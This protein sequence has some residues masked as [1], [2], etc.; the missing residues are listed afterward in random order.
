EYTSEEYYEEDEYEVYLNTRSES[1]PK[2]AVSKNKRRPVKFQNPPKI[3]V[4]ELEMEEPIPEPVV[5]L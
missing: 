2:N 4:K 5:E 3:T 1:Y